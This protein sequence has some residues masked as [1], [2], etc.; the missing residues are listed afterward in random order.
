MGFTKRESDA[1]FELSGFF[2][3]NQ[4]ALL[5]GRFVKFVPNNKDKDSKK[6]RPFALIKVTEDTGAI[7]NVEV[8][9][10]GKKK[11]E[12]V[13]RVA[14]ID[15]IVGVSW[16]WGISSLLDA[17]KDI[18]KVVRLTVNGEATNPNGGKPMKL[19]DVEVED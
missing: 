19:F 17:E 12:T 8:P 7:I 9:S 18:G 16:S 4:G 10:E 5:Q 1:R 11:A 14:V 13:E 3:R 15:D 6:W 2:V